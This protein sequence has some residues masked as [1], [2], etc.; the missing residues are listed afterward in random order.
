MPRS[1]L[2]PRTPSSGSAP[3]ISARGYALTL[4]SRRDYTV[5]ELRTKLI[6]RGYDEV[7]IGPLL[8]DL[9]TS[10]ALDDRRVAAAH[11]RTAAGIKGRGR[12]RIARELSARGI[13]RGIADAVL[14]EMNA[15]AEIDGLRRI[16]ARKRYPRKPSL[17]ERRRMYQH[18]M[19]RGFGSDAIRKAL[20]GDLEGDD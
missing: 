12:Y 4:L 13:P 6:D 3:R 1:A 19:R 17:A 11:V 20:G 15:T 8:G 18:L 9:G 2:A 16:L 10:G 7:A 14:A 5:H